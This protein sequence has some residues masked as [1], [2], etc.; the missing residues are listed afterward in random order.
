MN[1][2]PKTNKKFKN[3]VTIL[4]V[5]IIILFPWLVKLPI[6]LPDLAVRNYVLHKL[7]PGT[8]RDETVSAIDGE[9]WKLVS[10]HDRGLRINYKAHNA[11][12]DFEYGANIG[13][14]VGV[15][16]MKIKLG[17]FYA[18][19]HTAVFA[20]LAFDESDRLTEVFVYRE[21]EAP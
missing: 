5:V 16:S 21:I 20:Y 3:I 12:F 11:D 19:F 9:R 7:P 18:P 4:F 6:S 15:R 17:E 2:D 10:T 1:G 8:S 13:E 14:L